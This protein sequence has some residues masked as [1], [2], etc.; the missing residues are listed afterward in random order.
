MVAGRAGLGAVGLT[1]LGLAAPP[2]W[3]S[4]CARPAGRAGLLAGNAPGGG[5]GER[6][7]GR[8]GG[9]QPPAPPPGGLAA[10]RPRAGATLAASPAPIRATGWWRGRGRCRPPATWPGSPTA[11]LVAICLRRLRPAAHPHRDAALAPVALVGQ[12]RR[13]RGRGLRWWRRS[14]TRCRCTRSTR[15]SATRSASRPWPSRCWTPSSGCRRRRPAGAGGRGRVT[16]GA[17]PPRPR[18]RA[19]A[20]AL[21][22]LGGDAG[23]GGAGGRPGRAGAGGTRACSRLAIGAC[24]RCCRWRPGR[25]SCATGCTTW[26][27]SS[28]APW[29]T[30]C[31]RCCSVAATPWWCSGWASSSAEGS[32]LVVAAATLAVAAAFQPARRR[33]QQAVDR[34]F[35]R[36][37]Y[38]AARTID[39]FSDPAARP[40]RPGRP[41]RELLAVVDQTMQPTQASLWLRPQSRPTSPA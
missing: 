15:R 34:R 33:I 17:L 9:G 4:C 40:G 21:G 25:R 37:R 26:T 31:S 14:L 8:G 38:D 11:S 29:P 35:N 24:W 39:A 12:G 20:A 5:G 27:A 18:G 23:R 41:D 1:L 32:S 28:A 36:R 6:G 19:P 30:G 2:G 3:I 10:A 16:G 13:G 7:H 22:G